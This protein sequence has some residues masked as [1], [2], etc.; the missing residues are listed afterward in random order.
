MY[1]INKFKAE[2]HKRHHPATVLLRDVDFYYEVYRHIYD[3]AANSAKIM[4][5]DAIINLTMYIE[6]NAT[7]G[8]APHYER[9]YRCIGDLVWHWCR[10]IGVSGRDYSR[11]NDFAS[12]AIA[13]APA[14]G[15]LRNW[16]TE[17][18]LSCDFNRLKD[19]A[20]YF[21]KQDDTLS[22]AYPTLKFR[23]DLYMKLVSNNNIAACKMLWSDLAFN[24][25]D[26]EGMTILQRLAGLFNK[27]ANERKVAHNLQTLCPIRL[28]A[29]RIDGENG[30]R[31][32]TLVNKDGV[33]Y[34][35]VIIPTRLHENGHEYCFIGLLVT[36]LGRTYVNGPHVWKNYET[37]EQWN[38]H[39]LWQGI[40]E[41][42]KENAKTITFTSLF[43]KKMSLYEDHYT[44]LAT[45]NTADVSSDAFY[46]DDI[47][48]TDFIAWMSST[49]RVV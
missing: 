49:G 39:E 34:Q 31:T 13:A 17:S 27:T 9:M 43:G 15:S 2:W 30:N 29:Y 4:S 19:V 48:L 21:A 46:S 22:L 1:T 32:I 7:I 25:R 6:N 40:E 18:I 35:N 28:E 26:K 3:I 42:E 45:H 8:L 44:N 24:W 36:Y 23:E 5:E 12:E 37:Y 11:I 14:N 47:N 38:G 41:C 20:M 33:T 16:V 10:K